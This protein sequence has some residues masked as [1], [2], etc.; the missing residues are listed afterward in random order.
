[1]DKELETFFLTTLAVLALRRTCLTVPTLE[2]VSTTVLT[3]KMLEWFAQV[4]SFDFCKSEDAGVVC[5]GGIPHV[6]LSL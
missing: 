1:M 6:L 5:S 3:L 4:R 2:L